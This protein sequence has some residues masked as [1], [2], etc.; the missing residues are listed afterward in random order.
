MI[1]SSVRLACAL[2]YF[3]GGSPYDLMCKYGISYVEVMRSVWT[4]VKAVNTFSDFH[5][6]Y[7]S[8][9]ATQK[10]IAAEFRDVS[11]VKFDNCVGAI[12]GKRLLS[13][14]CLVKKSRLVSSWSTKQ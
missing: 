14:S 9:H 8:D 5:I 12:D 7:P 6:S 11:G 2:R 1:S 10:K 4:V 13:I 3:A